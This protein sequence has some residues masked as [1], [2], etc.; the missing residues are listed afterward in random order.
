MDAVPVAQLCRFCVN[1]AISDVER[2]DVT[3]SARYPLIRIYRSD[4]IARTG[5]LQ[6]V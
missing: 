6:T 1:R 5:L 3:T 2:R 4:C